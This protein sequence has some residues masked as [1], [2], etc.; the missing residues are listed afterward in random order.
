MFDANY[1]EIAEAYD[2][3]AL[4]HLRGPANLARLLEKG[5][6]MYALIAVRRP[7][8]VAASDLPQRNR[9]RMTAPIAYVRPPATG[10]SRTG[11][12]RLPRRRSRMTR[13]AG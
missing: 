10:H 12:P 4:D 7:A 5:L 11:R 8:G 6:A 1:A 2:R 3:N 13:G 9:A